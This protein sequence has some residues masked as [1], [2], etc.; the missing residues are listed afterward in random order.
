MKPTA[1]SLVWQDALLAARILA[2]DPS[3]GATIKAGAGPVREL[4]RDYFLSLVDPKTPIVKVPANVDEEALVGGLDVIRTVELKKRTYTTGLISRAMGG[5][6]FLAMAERLREHATALLTQAFDRHAT[7]G[8]IAFDEGIG[9]DEALSLRLTER[10]AFQ[11][12]LDELAYPDCQASPTVSPISLADARLLIKQIELTQEI[13]EGV[14]QASQVLGIA[15]IRAGLFA[16]RTIRVIT[17]L[18]GDTQV[19]Q[20][21]IQT[22]SRL[23]FGHRMTQIPQ[24]SE[25][26]DS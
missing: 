18:R 23:V 15:S 3:L 20:A 11:L 12:C 14:L 25:D 17:A 9:V 21:D 1:E 10:L 22:G 2:V 5:F 26:L 4:W 7:F 24:S 16:I 13:Y 19:T 6:I 8:I